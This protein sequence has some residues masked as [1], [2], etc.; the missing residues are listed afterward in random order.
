M[1]KLTV[2][3]SIKMLFG[4][5]MN[6]CEAVETINQSGVYEYKKF[7][8]PNFP[9]EL[10]EQFVYLLLNKKQ[11]LDCKWDKKT[12]GDIDIID[13]DDKI[14]KDEV[15]CFSS[16]GP[17]TFGPAEP[18]NILH[19]VDATEV[20]TGNIKIYE[21]QM[22]NISD[23]WKNLILSG[24]D[25]IDYE[26]TILDEIEL[27]KKTK[28]QLKELCRKRKISGFSKYKKQE[29]VNYLLTTKAGSGIKPIK[30]YQKY[31]DEGK[32][33]RITP[34]ELLEQLGDECH[35]VFNGTIDELL[36]DT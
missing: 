20:I 12:P 29:L 33:P 10:S 15:K 17:I 30:T 1:E 36:E 27:N 31:C 26:D 5:Y 35:E 28:E 18:W 23:D 21:V 9:S 25:D 32:R 16:D 11:G 4:V 3:E 2:I 6:Y 14:K 19:L 8:K 22:S 24:S 13:D 34:T 7:R